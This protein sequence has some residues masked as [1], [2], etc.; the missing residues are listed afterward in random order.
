MLKYTCTFAGLANLDLRG[1]SRADGPTSELQARREKYAF[2]EKQ[3]SE[4]ADGI[5]LGSDVVARNRE[6]LRA[7]GVTH[8]INC[9]GF[10]Y[11][12]YFKDEITYLVLYLQGELPV[13]LQQ[14]ITSSVVLRQAVQV[15]ILLVTF[16]CL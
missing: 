10:L 7:A 5:F 16:G 14:N 9:V 11:P 2:F 12:A 1:L 4:V 13:R 8:V 3:C 15:V 6:T